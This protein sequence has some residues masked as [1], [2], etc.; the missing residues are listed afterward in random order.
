MNSDGPLSWLILSQSPTGPL[1]NPDLQ[2]PQL[3]Q[4]ADPASVLQGSAQTSRVR[5]E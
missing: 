4:V 3:T 5:K 1:R 2:T